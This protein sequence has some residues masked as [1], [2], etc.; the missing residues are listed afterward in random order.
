MCIYNYT[1][2]Y[3]ILYIYI[4]I[5]IHTVNISKHVQCIMYYALFLFRM[6]QTTGAGKS[7]T[8]SQSPTRIGNLGFIQQRCM[9]FNYRK[10]GIKVIVWN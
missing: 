9:Y 10:T 8:D 1:Y 2:I 6:H 7:Q 5:Y 3:T 4:I